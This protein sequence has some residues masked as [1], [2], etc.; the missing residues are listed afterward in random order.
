MTNYKKT[1]LSIRVA[2]AFFIVAAC[3]FVGCTVRKNELIQLNIQE[4]TKRYLD[5]VFAIEASI[6]DGGEYSLRKE[7]IINR[8]LEELTYEIDEISVSSPDMGNVSVVLTYPD[9]DEYLER[10]DILVRD[11]NLFMDDVLASRLVETKLLPLTFSLK[12]ERWNVSQESSTLVNDFIN[13]LADSVPFD[14]LTEE[15]AIGLTEEALALI[16]AGD[17]EN[18]EDFFSDY[19]D[20]LLDE[21]ATEESI[22]DFCSTYFAMSSLE[23]QVIA[24]ADNTCSIE[25]SGL[26]PDIDYY[27]NN[28][29]ADEEF[30]TE[31]YA[32]I[33]YSEFYY[34]DPEAYTNKEIKGMILDA[35]DSLIIEDSSALIETS[36][37]IN[38]TRLRGELYFSSPTVFIEK[39]IT[40]DEI[41]PEY[42]E[43]IFQSA[44]NNLYVDGR[45]NS[46]DYSLLMGTEPVTDDERIVIT[47]N[48]GTDLYSVSYGIIRGQ[49]ELYI[50]TWS[51]SVRGTVYTY[52]TYIDD[53]L[54]RRGE[55]YLTEY[56]YSDDV[57]ISIPFEGD[58]IPSG[59]YQIL[60]NNPD[61][62]LL[63]RI[64]LEVLEDIDSSYF[65]EDEEAPETI[66][67]EGESMTYEECETEDVFRVLFENQSGEEVY[68][69]SS[70][71]S[72]YVRVVTMSYY[73]EGSVFTYDIYRDG[74]L[75]LSDLEY[76][77]EE[78]NND[79]VLIKYE[80][81]IPGDYVFALYNPETQLIAYVFVS[82]A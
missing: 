22:L 47:V 60:V 4:A 37:L 72:I 67:V 76:E 49:I 8:V 32:E 42:E 30:M 57:Y 5:E 31:L 21:D 3:L 74:E 48:N 34:Q 58:I 20:K 46:N 68:S 71:D 64:T 28:L 15:S 27:Y 19:E 38:I 81:A 24:F 66:L 65:T 55:E 1:S 35:M 36:Y 52:D 13:S 18:L 44:A 23:G 7:I 69:Y 80:N 14:I 50:K 26:V 75:L 45:I 59:R 2:V 82:V 54:V 12:E 62:S 43:M 51:Y 25:I 70:G 33:I 63:G 6:D 78:N 79:R 39:F 17:Y 53:V 41:D 9:I 11:E 29:I 77:L 61:G 16:G 73:E 10:N 56:D 40:L